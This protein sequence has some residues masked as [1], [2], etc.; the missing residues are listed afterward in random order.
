M[1]R[2]SSSDTSSSSEG[3][4][5]GIFGAIA[6]AAGS[7]GVNDDFSDSA[8]QAARGSSD[9]GPGSSATLRDSIITDDGSEPEISE[10]QMVSITH[11]RSAQLVDGGSTS[12]A[13]SRDPYWT[14]DYEVSPLAGHPVDMSEPFFPPA[15]LTSAARPWDHRL[16]HMASES[17]IGAGDGSPV[18]R[19][20]SLD[21]RAQIDDRS[22]YHNGPTNSSSMSRSYDFESHPHTG[23][24]LPFQQATST[25]S[26][27]AYSSL[28]DSDH[29]AG[30]PGR[31]DYP[32]SQPGTRIG[33]V[34][35]T[36]YP[37]APPPY[38][39][40]NPQL[41]G[42]HASESQQAGTGASQGAQS[43]RR[44]LFRFTGRRQ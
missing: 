28:F 31:R 38:S 21:E 4:A 12:P 30:M 40:Q 16:G 18:S 8:W 10:A 39:D 25:F 7:A 22:G 3:P 43:R 5:K 42:Y 29:V 15:R 32:W 1:P 35:S 44:R 2:S 33:T 23:A 13:T 19:S 17:F 36:G 6:T 37:D 27:D 20:G 34:G 24:P 9:F 41:Y 26:P 11:V 14:D